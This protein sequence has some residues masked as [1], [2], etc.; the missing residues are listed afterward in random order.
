MTTPPTDH[1]ALI[2]ERK[3]HEV[4]RRQRRHELFAKLAAKR[5]MP[6][7][8]QW[9]GL[10]RVPGQRPKVIAEIKLRS[11]SAGQIRPRNVGEIVR[12]AQAYE[13]AGA[14]AISVLCDGPGFGGSPLDLARAARAVHTPLLFKE[15][16]LGEVQLDVARAAGASLVLLLVRVL[17]DARLITLIS[18]ARARGLEP[19]VEAADAD[20]LTRAIATPATIIGVNARDLRSFSVDAQHAA[21][22][23]GRIP[24]ERIAVF[25]SGVRERADF[26]RVAATRADAVLIGEGLMRAPEPGTALRALLAGP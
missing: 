4:A 26:Q 16:V 13:Q 23:V 12:I 2:I 11:P 19:V 5:V 18:E 22:L 7:R 21:D 8:A 1:L 24:A 6:S 15:F 17:S 14:G 25:M 9:E 20:E 3:A 10:R